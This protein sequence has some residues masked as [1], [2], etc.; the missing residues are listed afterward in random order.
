M[1]KSKYWLFIHKLPNG[2]FTDP[3]LMPFGQGNFSDEIV[4][5][6]WVDNTHFGD[7]THFAKNNSPFFH[8]FA[9]EM[10]AVLRQLKPSVSSPAPVT[11]I[12]LL[13]ASA[14]FHAFAMEMGAVLRQLKAFPAAFRLKNVEEEEEEEEEGTIKVRAKQKEEKVWVGAEIPE[15][16][17]SNQDE[18]LTCRDCKG[19]FPFSAGE[20]EYFLSKGYAKPA[21]CSGCRK[22]KKARAR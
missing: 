1:P 7:S 18:Q 14:A 3:A 6:R 4:G 15:K 5:L 12:R 8:A 16:A 20:Q 2:G 10:G 11:A 22:A 17:A 21:R 19:T 13:G 9:M